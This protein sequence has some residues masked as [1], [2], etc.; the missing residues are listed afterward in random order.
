MV[1][2]GNLKN[3]IE[4]QMDEFDLEVAEEVTEEITSWEPKSLFFDQK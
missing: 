3:G 4:I 2:Y 1:E